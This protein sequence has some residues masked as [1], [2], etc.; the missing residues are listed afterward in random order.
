M[1]ETLP[2][3]EIQFSTKFSSTTYVKKTLTKGFSVENKGMPPPAD[4]LL[5]QIEI[6][7]SFQPF[8]LFQPPVAVPMVSTIFDKEIA[9]RIILSL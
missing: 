3:Y 8:H 2:H 6:P 7:S 4:L 5:A 1:S 9:H